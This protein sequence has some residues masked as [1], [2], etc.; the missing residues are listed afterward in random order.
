MKLGIVGHA[1]EKFDKWSATKAR[2]A[3]RDLIEEYRPD[4]VVSGG[5]HMG[6]I[7]KWAVEEAR[8]HFIDVQ[9][10]LPKVLR[11]EGG[12]KQR[13]LRIA[14]NSDVV[15]SIVVTAFPSDYSGV[16]FPYCYHCKTDSHIK[17]GGCW[18][19]KEARKLG[20]VGRVI[21]IPST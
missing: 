2:V 3:I 21:E 19:V 7:D 11:W 15:V 18:T 4:L 6:G 16:R 9:E 1:A 13:N 17:S 5:C 20:K 12:Y 8:A 10:F 14:E